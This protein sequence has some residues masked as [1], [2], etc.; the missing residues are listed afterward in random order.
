M[1]KRRCSYFS[2]RF[3][4]AAVLLLLLAGVAQLAATDAMPVVKAKQ[5]E[6]KIR[7]DGMLDEPA[8]RNAGVIPDLIQQEP[9]PGEPTPFRTEVLM[10]VDDQNLYI[11]FVCH[12]PDPA[13]ITVHTMQRDG[14]MYGDAVA[15]VFDT[16]GDRRRGYYFEIN[17]AG[18]RLDGLISG[19]EDIST[20]WDGIWDA[21]T[22]RTQDGWSAEIRIP[23]QSLRFTPGAE[24]WGFNVQRWIARDR[25][26]LR[27]AGT[28]L[29][30]GFQDL[31]RAGRLAGVTGLRQG[32]GLSV[33]P[34]ILA[35]RETDL[36]AGQRTAQGDYGL[37]VTY[38]LTPDLTAVLTLN[39]DFAE[40]EVDNRQVNL[41]RFPLFFPE[42]RSFFVEGSNL[43]AFGAGLGYSFIPFFSRRVGLYD[44]N[45]V[46]LLAGS[47]V[48]GQVG[49]WNLA[50]LDAVTGNIAST[51][52]TNLLAGRMAYDV[53]NHFTV[54]TVITDGNP[55]GLHNNTLVGVDALWQTS[56]FRGNKNL[57]IGEW[58]AWT[59]GNTT[60]DQRT[61]WG[62]KL[63]Y[64]NDLWDMFLLYKEF[65][66]GLDPA[67]GFLPRPGT[68]WYQSGGAYQPRPEGGIF[69]W[70]RQF[71]FEFYATYV[72]DLNGCVESWRVFTA[73]FNAQT[74]SGEHLEANV[75]PQF[76]R[77]EDSFEISDGVV[78]PPGEYHFT[79]YRVE[80]Q[81]SRH[82]PWR[83]GTTVW[84]GDFYTG[85]LTQ[86]ES[87][88][89]FTTP[90]GHL[91]L[92]LQSENDFAHLPEGNFIQRLWQ[93]KMAYAFTPDFILSSYTQYDSESRNLG[94]NT[95]LR[96]TLR[97]GNDLYVVWNH[98]WEHPIGSYNR[99]MLQPISDQLAVKLRWTFRR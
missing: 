89:T 49:K 26:M 88:I 83:V 35:Y 39:T 90:R 37:D 38:N 44:G 3:H 40:T 64:P 59:G 60:S 14:N 73:P 82:R 65:G 18:A 91:Q 66:D 96:W 85:S 77:L 5:V 13:L 55:D 36:R 57:S 2:H 84:F 92:E 86:L 71:Y 78:I 80:A 62:F 61:G 72:E 68:R 97:P 7:I 58:V 10:L 48:L 16:F 9:K 43:F 8:W 19:S 69:D 29:D 54:G 20:D 50:L 95:R 17:T 56:T 6:G 25:I 98:S 22:R 4:R 75:A 87:V 67:L 79:R 23:A 46:P 81:S 53:N 76:E 15:V 47:K 63:D 99:S 42:K 41:T 70:V 1:D 21:R 24:S 52:S 74:E 34:F 33:S 30:A 51:E 45:R 94:T 27:W 11:G 12:D 93:F 31:R 32:K 28:T